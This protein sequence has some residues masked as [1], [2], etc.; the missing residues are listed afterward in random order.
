MSDEGKLFVGGL[1][2]DTDEQALEEHFSKYGQITEVRVIK[3]RETMASRGFG[4]V[5]FDNPEDAKDALQAMNGKSVD[6]RQIRVGQAEKKRGGGRGYGGGRGGGGYGNRRRGGGYW[7]NERSSY[8]G[9]GRYDQSERDGYLG[10]YRS[11]SQS[12]YNSYGS[13]YNRDYDCTSAPLFRRIKQLGMEVEELRTNK[14]AGG[15]ERTAVGGKISRSCGAERPTCRAIGWCPQVELQPPPKEQTGNTRAERTRTSTMS[16]EGKLFIGGLNFET[17]EQALEEVFCKY[18]QISE[19]RVIK[20][21]DTQ[22]SRGFGFITFE[23]PGDAHDAMQAM[24]GKSLDGRQIRVDHAE[25]KT[26]GGGGY[27]GGGRSYG[28]GRGGGYGARQYETRDNFYR[29]DNY[30]RGRGSGSY[31][32]GGRSTYQ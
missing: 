14:M 5:T 27:G 32:Y 26:G 17:D 20:D 30:T 18:G 28:R 3:N 19:V 8:G 13:R 12:S 2:L 22:T 11:Q 23:N 4:F 24:N 25:K 16:E 29:Q 10:G 9:G 6:G 21:R 15:R 1:S 7:D 31:N